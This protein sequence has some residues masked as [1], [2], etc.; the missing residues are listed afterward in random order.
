MIGQ[1]WLIRMSRW[2]RNPP[3]PRKVALVLAVVAACL[4]IWG[5]EQIWG[6]PEALTVR[7]LRK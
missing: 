5:V 4:A 7:S 6:W 1:T 3:P 2:A